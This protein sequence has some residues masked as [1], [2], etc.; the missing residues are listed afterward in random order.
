[1]FNFNFDLLSELRGMYYV[2]H[3]KDS[4][5]ITEKDFLY[6]FGHKY[7]KIYYLV[8]KSKGENENGNI[9]VS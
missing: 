5:R 7:K 2:S 3:Q 6:K 4:Y 1:L 8:F 9:N